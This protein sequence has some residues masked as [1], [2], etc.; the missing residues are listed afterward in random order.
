MLKSLCLLFCGLILVSCSKSQSVATTEQPGVG[1]NAEAFTGTDHDR[2]KLLSAR[3]LL[4]QTLDHA[5]HHGGL[6]L[7][8]AP[9]VCEDELDLDES[10]CQPMSVLT[11]DQRAQCREYLSETARAMIRLYEG[12]GAVEPP[13]FPMKLVPTDS[14]PLLAGGVPVPARTPLGPNGEIEVWR[15]EIR[16]LSTV[17]LIALEAH[18]AGHKIPYSGGCEEGEDGKW[19]VEDDCRVGSFS[20]GRALLDAAG[21]AIAIYYRHYVNPIP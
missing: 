12:D 21:S 8:C 11:S 14:L 9:V 16:R 20:T 10:Y 6:A 18:E 4:I 15:G 17:S 19:Y 1:G 5:R 7:L 2:N 3:G 13:V